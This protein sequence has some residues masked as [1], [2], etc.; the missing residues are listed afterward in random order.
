M[1]QT[2][3]AGILEAI[4]LLRYISFPSSKSEHIVDI[5]NAMRDFRTFEAFNVPEVTY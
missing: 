5:Y 3:H 2:F 1:N 4:I